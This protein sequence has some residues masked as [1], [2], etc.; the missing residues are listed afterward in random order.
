MKLFLVISLITSLSLNVYLALKDVKI[1]T[2]GGQ[3]K[4]SPNKEFTVMANSRRNNNPLAKNKQIYAE[5]TLHRGYIADKVVRRITVY[6]I[7]SDR[8]MAYREI[9][10]AIEWDKDGKK[11]TVNTP[12]FCLT[13]NVNPETLAGG[14]FKPTPQ[15]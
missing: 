1:I 5:I 6:P 7:S 2:G 10:D 8:E 14:D 13:L 3:N 11:V 4:Q 15:P 12:D 9:G